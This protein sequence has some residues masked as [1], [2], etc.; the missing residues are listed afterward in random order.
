MFTDCPKCGSNKAWLSRDRVDLTLRCLCGV[1]K[2]VFSLLDSIEEDECK[3]VKL[4]LP[5]TN[6]HRTM[7]ALLCLGEADGKAIVAHLRERGEEFRLRVIYGH[8]YVLKGRG[9]VR[10]TSLRRCVAGGS[11]WCVTEEAQKLLRE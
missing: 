8:L 11:V 3:S 7:M 2:V 9:V 4:P 1:N 10:T 6:L 5:N